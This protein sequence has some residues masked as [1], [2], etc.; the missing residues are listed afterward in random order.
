MRLVLCSIC[1]FIGAVLFAIPNFTRRELLFAVPVPRDFRQSAAGRH[2]ISM[3]RLAIAATVI[4]GVCALLLSPPEL[5][6]AAATV[7]PIAIVIVGAVSFYWQNR[8]LAPSAVQFMHPHEAEVTSAPD[9]LPHYVWLAPG[10]FVILAAAAAWLYLNW[11]SI[12]ARFPVHY[13]ADGVPDRWTD[14]TARGV[15]GPLFFGAAISAWLLIM[16]VAGWFGSRRS[17]FRSIMLGGGIA[18]GYMMGFLFALIALQPLLRIPV[19]GIALFP[20][21][22]LIPLLILMS[23]KMNEPG[24]SMD[25][26][27]NECWHWGIFYYNP[28]DAALFVEKREGLGYT[29]NFGNRWSWVLMMGLALVIAAPHFL[30]G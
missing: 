28:N 5:L 19:W 11:D 6:N 7:V 23:R 26:T 22:V 24:E 16:S 30:L 15:Y 10:P 2:A 12:P 13:G 17:R 1:A 29:F 9:T 18:I 3:F 4:A 14:R 8:K 25:P 20:M 27:P 21:A